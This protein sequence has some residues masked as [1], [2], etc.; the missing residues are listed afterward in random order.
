MSTSAWTWHHSAAHK[1]VAHREDMVV[2]LRSAP[3]LLKTMNAS[4]LRWGFPWRRRIVVPGR[5]PG[6][7]RRLAFRG[8]AIKSGKGARSDVAESWEK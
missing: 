6:L 3:H 4:A 1:G 8:V 7:L 5:R 2:S